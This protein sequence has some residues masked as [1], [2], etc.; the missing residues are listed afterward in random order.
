METFKFSV[1]DGYTNNVF[2]RQLSSYEVASNIISSYPPGYIAT[3]IPVDR[4]FKCAGLV[5]D[6]KELCKE[7]STKYLNID[8]DYEN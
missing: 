5:I 3:A 2:Y 4:L 8:L 7:L 6:S 1:W